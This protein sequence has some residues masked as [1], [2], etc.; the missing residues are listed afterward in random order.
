MIKKSYFIILNKVLYKDYDLI[1]EAL[2]GDG[3][4]ISFFAKNGV[5]KKLINCLQ[6]GNII[7]ATYT[8]KNE[9]AYFREVDLDIRYNFYFYRND[10]KSYCFFCDIISIARKISKHYSSDELYLNL[11][12]TLVKAQQNNKELLNYYNDFLYF[13]LS[14]AGIKLS[15]VDLC[16][17]KLLNNESCIVF[18]NLKTNQLSLVNKSNTFNNSKKYNYNSNLKKIYLQNLFLENISNSLKLKF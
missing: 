12:N 6:I 15:I 4:N 14:L 5:K 10:I 3:Y 2:S 16:D 9:F 13:C 7:K 17:M 11:L 18:F 8:Q 1:L